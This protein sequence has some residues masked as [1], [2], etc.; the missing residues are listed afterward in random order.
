MKTPPEFARIKREARRLEKLAMQCQ[1]E[2]AEMT[3]QVERMTERLLDL[4]MDLSDLIIS[5]RAL[6]K[7]E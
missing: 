2:R 7:G 3:A 4:Q 6:T 5:L 1:R